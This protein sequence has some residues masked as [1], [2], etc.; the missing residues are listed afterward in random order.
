MTYQ[1]IAAG[2]LLALAAVSTDALANARVT[3]GHFAPFAPTLQGTSVSIRVNGTVALQNVVFGQF[4][5]YLTLGPAGRYTIDVLPTGSTTVAIT[6]SVDLAN[7]TDYTV[8][9]VGDGGNQPLGLLPLTDDNAAPPAGQVKV[10]VVHA[11]PF[12]NTLPATEVSVRDNANVVVGGLSRVPFRGASGYLTL[13][14]ATYDLK[15]STPDGN[16]TLIDPKPVALPAG[17]IF[18]LVA[19]GG[20]N[21]YAT[22]ITAITAGAAPTNP[23]PTFAIGPVKVRVAHFAP[24]ARTLEGTAVRVTVNGNQILNNVRFRQ[25]SPELTLTQG[26][27]A[28][29]VFPE[30]S[31][32]AAISGTVELEGNRSYTLA[33]V[34][35]GSQQPLALQRFEDQTTT[36][37]AGRYALRI[38]HTAPFAN[39]PAATGV[40][41]RTDGG[42]VVAGL[43]NVP[44]GAAS[45]YLDLPV[46]ALDVKV[47]TP[48]GTANLID[49]APL[50]LPSGAIV[51][52]YAVGDGINQPLGIVAVP[53][54]DVPLE[55]NVNTSADGLWFNPAVNGQGWS[56]YAIPGQNRLVGA[57]YTYFNDGSGR[58]LWYTLD[59]CRSVTGESV[60][61]Q[62][63]GFN[64]REAVLSVYES[65]GGAFGQPLP[66]VTRDVGTLTVRFLN[67]SEAEISYRLGGLSVPV[68]RVFNLVPRAGCTI[69]AP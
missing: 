60:C 6:A 10:R 36:P 31:T 45:G 41:I 7:N 38:A 42:A 29:Q 56:F 17:R 40:S 27:Y 62:P 59:S 3:V 14:A 30:G 57:W 64:N 13:P 28:I 11:A 34:G 25:F 26:A 15:I 9:A 18:T 20:A 44:Y 47:A 49:L 65:T 66:I 37:A 50:N 67:C 19:T 43:S 39:T 46:A 68:Q 23:L 2:A 48:D 21:G 69:S 33:A 12:A 53:V 61:A 8:L 1:R 54:G 5:D 24:F 55:A 16:T 35:N 4:T 52:A 22:G 32:T 63:G 51:T 58:H